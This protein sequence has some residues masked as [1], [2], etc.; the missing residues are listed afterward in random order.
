M[1]FSNFFQAWL[2]PDEVKNGTNQPPRHGKPGTEVKALIF[3]TERRVLYCCRV[4][5]CRMSQFYD[6]F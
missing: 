2:T 6:L 1:T 4:V 3:V 5:T